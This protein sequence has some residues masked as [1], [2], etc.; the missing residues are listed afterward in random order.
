MKAAPVQVMGKYR[1]QQNDKTKSLQ[2]CEKVY[3][4]L[5]IF[6]KASPM[7]ITETEALGN[8]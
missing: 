7:H 4:L 2:Q 6:V 1:K 5:Q 8:T 3:S